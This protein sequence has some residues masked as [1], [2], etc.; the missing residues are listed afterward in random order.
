M[1]SPFQLGQYERVAQSMRHALLTKPDGVVAY[2]RLGE[3]LSLGGHYSA[4]LEP[5]RDGAGTTYYELRAI[6]AHA[7]A[8]RGLGRCDEA[9]ELRASAA[10]EHPTLAP[11]LRVGIIDDRVAC[12]DYA[13]AEVAAWS[14]LAALEPGETGASAHAALADVYAAEGRAE[15]AEYELLF[16]RWLDPTPWRVRL[17]EARYRASLRD[18]TGV[19]QLLPELERERPRTPEVFVVRAQWQT[20]TGRVFE[21]FTD[22]QSPEWVEHEDA[23]VR[24]VCEEAATRMST[25][26][27]PFSMFDK[28]PAGAGGVRGPRMPGARRPR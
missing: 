8:L 19:N 16:A 14:A 22:C 2:A 1:P 20:A 15:D 21:V 18:W 13:A 17:A 26:G 11:S 10:E 3:A 27:G 28:R 5:F 24:R 9:A 7:D 6:A 23:R 4:S 25:M 12:G